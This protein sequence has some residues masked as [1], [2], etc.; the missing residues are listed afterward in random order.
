MLHAAM[1]A[2][3]RENSA[4]CSDRQSFGRENAL[5]IEREILDE[6]RSNV[7]GGVSH[8][9]S[10][11][12]L[13][14]DLVESGKDGV[15]PDQQSFILFGAALQSSHQNSGHEAGVLQNA[16]TDQFGDRPR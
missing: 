2:D 9:R 10:E 16:A 8:R 11:K 15:A 6:Q 1:L 13:L 12:P 4:A 7:S 3:P 5:D 14:A